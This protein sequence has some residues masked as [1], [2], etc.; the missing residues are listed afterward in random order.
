MKNKYVFVAVMLCAILLAGMGL[1][2]LYVG[3]AQKQEEDKEITVVTSFYPMYIA[4]CNVVGDADHVTLKNLSEPQT[5]CLHDFQ[6]TPE[7]ILQYATKPAVLS[8][9]WQSSF[10]FLSLIL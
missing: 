3:Y 6:L 9:F 2:N 4:A 1:T 10:V 7:D 8:L 5:G